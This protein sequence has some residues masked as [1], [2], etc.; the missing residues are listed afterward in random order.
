MDNKV[1]FKVSSKVGPALKEESMPING[2]TCRCTI[3]AKGVAKKTIKRSQKI[4]YG[5]YLD[6]DKKHYWGYMFELDGELVD[7]YIMMS[8]IINTSIKISEHDLIETIEGAEISVQEIRE[9]TKKDIANAM[10]L[11][12]ESSS[13]KSK[14]V[15]VARVYTTY[16]DDGCMAFMYV[17]VA[18]SD[19]YEM[20]YRPIIDYTDVLERLTYVLVHNHVIVNDENGDRIEIDEESIKDSVANIYMGL[21]RR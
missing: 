5:W 17:A 20:H 11:T 10:A 6:E 4:R 14:G 8:H 13:I 16:S 12:V 21:P 19:V 2:F 7:E 3:E 9:P 15:E 18:N 1:K